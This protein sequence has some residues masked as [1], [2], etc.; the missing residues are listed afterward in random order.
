MSIV[1]GEALSQF[2]DSLLICLGDSKTGKEADYSLLG[3]C[4][5]LCSDLALLRLLGNFFFFDFSF[6]ITL[7]QY[8]K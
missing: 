8:F 7:T 6:Y 2:L 4:L 1:H 3:C 5:R